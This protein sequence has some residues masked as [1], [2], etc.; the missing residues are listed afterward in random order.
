M[1]NPTESYLQTITNPTLSSCALCGLKSNACKGHTSEEY[2]MTGD[3]WSASFG[4][5][6][7]FNFDLYTT[8]YN[9]R[10]EALRSYLET[11]LRSGGTI[12]QSFGATKPT[13]LGD[14]LWNLQGTRRLDAAGNIGEYDR[15][16]IA[17]CWTPE[18]LANHIAYRTFGFNMRIAT[19]LEL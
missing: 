3:Y 2:R 1:S 9:D 6:E 15:C 17:E 16:F 11:T 14:T 12:L 7:E 4:Q 19:W 8:H 18:Y 13:D 5:G 10:R